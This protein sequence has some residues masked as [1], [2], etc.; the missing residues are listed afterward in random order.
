MSMDI[1][2]E[3][4]YAGHQWLK[5]EDT[6]SDKAD[7]WL[8]IAFVKLGEPDL[9]GHA[10]MA[11]AFGSERPMVLMAQFN[12]STAN[13]VGFGK[14]YEE[15]GWAVWEGEI[16]MASPDGPGILAHIQG[17][18][19]SQQYSWRGYSKSEAVKYNRER[20]GLDVYEVTVFEVC[21]VFKGV[22]PETHTLSKMHET[23]RDEDRKFQMEALAILNNVTQEA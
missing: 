8:K 20:D 6:N 12:H 15:A 16:N 7:N 18:G 1:Q 19:D 23:L 17:M 5:A 21:P 11:G 22:G 2:F 14:V 3:K 10:F 13:P 4:S 9:E